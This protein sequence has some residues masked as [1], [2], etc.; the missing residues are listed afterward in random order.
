MGEGDHQG[1]PGAVNLGPFV[2]VD[3][4]VTDRHRA[5]TDVKLM[6]KWEPYEEEEEGWEYPSMAGE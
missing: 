6:K 2:N 4:S 1:R 5:D 3:F